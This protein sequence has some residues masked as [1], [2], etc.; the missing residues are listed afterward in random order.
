VYD[1]QPLYGPSG[2]EANAWGLNAAGSVAGI[3]YQT[4]FGDPGVGA[5]WVNGALAFSLQQNPPSDL[6]RINTTGDC[7]GIWSVGNALHPLLLKG[8]AAVDLAPLV[9]AGAVATGIND[10]GRV[11]GIAQNPQ[12]FIFDSATNTLL[13]SI[14]PLPGTTRTEADAINNVGVIL[15]KCDDHGVVSDGPLTK[16]LGP[17]DFATDINDNGIA[18]GTIQKDDPY[19]PFPARCDTNLAA[20]TFQEIPIPGTG[21]GGAF[22]INNA[23][24]IVGFYD[25]SEDFDAVTS[26]FLYDGGSTVDLNQLISDPGWHLNIAYDINDRGQ[27]AGYGV[28]NGVRTAFLLTPRRFRRPVLTLPELVAILVGGVAVDGGGWAIWG[29]HIGPVDPWGPL[30]TLQGPKRDALIA[31]LMEEIA[32]SI[33]DPQAREAIR[34]ALV[35]VAQQRVGSLAKIAAKPTK[36]QSGSRKSK[37][38]SHQTIMSYFALRGRRPRKAR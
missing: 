36:R 35:N 18:C 8:G 19:L 32:R 23:G 21:G 37:P 28:L 24:A 22:A 9:G 20:P 6:W 5:I 12:T 10:S 3:S 4:Q 17:V 1:I 29:H 15:G 31:L 13:G 14:T 25:S 26:A 33:S 34:S 2:A 38:R 30:L 27:I 11:C 7:I 16:D